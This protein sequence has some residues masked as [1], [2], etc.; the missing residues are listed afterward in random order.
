[1]PAME[2]TTAP[3]RAAPAARS[4]WP[5]L[6]LL[7]LVLLAAQW[8]AATERSFWEDEA[9]TATVVALPLGQIPAATA[10]DFHP[11]LYY[12]LLAVWARAFGLDE[13]GLRA[14]SILWA[15]AAALAVYALGAGL[16][17]RRAGLI[18]AAL[19]VCSPLTLAY[20]HNA[21]Y[22]SMAAALAAAAVLGCD[23]YLRTGLRRYLALYAV[24]G[25][26][27]LYTVYLGFTVLAV[28]AVW[29]LARAW[30]SGG[31]RALGPWLLAHG[32]IAAGFAPWLPV[33][34]AQTGRGLA[35]AVSGAGWVTGLA[36]RAALVGFAFSA[37]ESLSPLSPVTWVGL[38]LTAVCLVAALL[39][40]ARPRAWAPALLLAGV[41][42]LAALVSVSAGYPNSAPQALA[43]RIF[44]ALPLFLVWVA[45]GAAA[46]RPPR[47]ALAAAGLVAVG[48]VGGLNY[49]ADRQLF[50]PF[51]AVPWRAIV[52]QVAAGAGPDDVVICNRADTTCGFYVRRAGLT[53]HGPEEGA[54]LARERRAPVWW[55][56]VHLAG[57]VYAQDAELRLLDALRAGASGAQEWQ[58]APQD[59]GI[60]WLKRQLLGQ[61]DYAYRVTLVRLA[62]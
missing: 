40:A 5:A 47:G 31:P 29:W 39:P 52:G 30:R 11:P 22:Y 25:L 17:S 50:Q 20:A 55:V 18:A 60:R 49:F 53:P 23:Q 42:A 43:R 10:A 32:L 21:R 46:L 41:V 15:S 12:L 37:G 26:A 62:P 9:W 3:F 28:C 58:F 35:P 14:F 38:A 16:I 7:L 57:D 34:L 27:L 1:M 8:R 36:L 48:V 33:L 44:F 6:A 13:P 54:A 4:P 19:F 51:I 61:N 2:T 24:A 59:P 45:A 56:Q